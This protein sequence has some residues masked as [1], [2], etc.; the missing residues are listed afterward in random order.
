MVK[1][2]RIFLF[3][4]G[5]SADKDIGEIFPDSPLSSCRD[6]E[7]IGNAIEGF[8]NGQDIKF[9]LS[10]LNLDCLTPFQ[11]KVLTEVVFKI[12]WGSVMTYKGVAE[13]IGLKNGARAVAGAVAA[14][15]FPIIIP[16]HR[17][18]HSDGKTGGY[19]GGEEMKTQLLRMEG[20]EIDDRGKINP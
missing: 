6:V 13:K 10:R 7:E 5:V 19:L 3:G 15:P 11:R 9:S 14:N 18:I 17:V 20:I 4:P 1:V 2:S 16:C 8:L 12:K